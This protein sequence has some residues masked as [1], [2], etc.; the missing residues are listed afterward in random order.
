MRCLERIKESIDGLYLGAVT[1]AT[2]TSGID[3]DAIVIPLDVG[4]ANL[5]DYATDLGEEMI[6]TSFLARLRT[7]SW[8][9]SD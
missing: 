1:S 6:K 4:D 7:I 9:Q 2:I 5:S 8:R 3:E